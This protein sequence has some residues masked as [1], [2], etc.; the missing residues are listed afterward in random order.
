MAEL[1][2]TLVGFSDTSAELVF[3][4]ITGNDFIALDNADSRVMLVIKNTNTQN[5]AVT[6]KAGDGTLA[7]LGDA[8]VTAGGSKTIAVPFS[9]VESARVK[10]MQGTNKGKVM[11]AST[12][13]AGGSL[14]NLSIAVLSVA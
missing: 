7:G 10:V 9:R 13:D 8:V 14:A 3:T 6:L 5:A 4:T 1:I 11:V 12:V 2:K